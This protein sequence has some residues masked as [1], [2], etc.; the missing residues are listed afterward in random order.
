MPPKGYLKRLRE[1][2]DQHD[3]L[4]IFDE[5][6]TA[7]GRLGS[8]FAAEEF[9]VT[10]DI[11]TMAKGLT[12]GAVP[13]G[14]VLV[15]NRIYDEFMD[16]PG[17]TIE[18]FHGYTYS[19]HPL[20]VAASTAALGVYEDEGLFERC[21]AMAPVL[22]SA[23]HSFKGEPHVIDVRN[24]GLMGAVELRSAEGA[25]GSRGINVVKSAFQQGLMVRVTVDTIA[26]SPPLIVEEKHIEQ[27]VD[28]LKGIIRAI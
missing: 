23:L 18:L 1:I 12:S 26:F 5:V 20:A 17:H 22:E 14:G 10:P 15:H 16:K 21:R 4:L 24:Y 27:T 28:I 11:I 25:P 13:M 19:S 2:C 8:S 7:F 9:G 3:V 6:I